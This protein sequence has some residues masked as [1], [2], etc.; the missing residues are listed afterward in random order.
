MDRLKTCPKELLFDPQEARMILREFLT[1]EFR[2]AGFSNAV[3]GI[4]GGVDSAVVAYLAAEALGKDN[5]LGVLLPYRTSDPKNIADAQLVV[6]RLGIR[7]EFVDISPMVDAYCE[8]YAVTDVQRR[9]NIMARM[10]MVILYDLSARERALVLG[11]SNKSEILVGYGT[12]YGDLACAVNPLG[13]LYKSQVWLLAEALGVPQQIIEKPPTADLWKGQT[14]E[15]ELGLKY[16]ELDRVLYYMFDKK[17]TDE[18][19]VEQGFPLELVRTIR[20]RHEKNKFK[21]HLPII[22]R[23]AD[24]L[25]PR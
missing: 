14:D 8:R 5:V 15:G 3:L 12:I 10:R 18:Q 6:E 24:R 2:N 16:S 21:T 23:V 22:A 13:D 1:V 17:M 4:S 20:T 9:G 19:L 7:S 11:T 25:L